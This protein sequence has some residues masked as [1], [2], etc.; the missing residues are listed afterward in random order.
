MKCHF[1]GLG[2]RRALCET[3][4]GKERERGKEDGKLTKISE[5]STK[6][7]R[8]PGDVWGNSSPPSPPPSVS[9]SATLAARIISRPNYARITFPVIKTSEMKTR[10]LSLL[11][12]INSKSRHGR[13][14]LGRG[15]EGGEEAKNSK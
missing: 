9:P 14:R 15:D 13:G 7:S 10:P 5:L 4:C 3:P 12:L 6:K 2:L 1:S 8:Q 11:T